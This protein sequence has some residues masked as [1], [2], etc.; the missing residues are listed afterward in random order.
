MSKPSI[1]VTAYRCVRRPSGAI[2]FCVLGILSSIVYPTD[3]NSYPLA[4]PGT[5]QPPA[6]ELTEDYLRFIPTIL[7]IA[8]PIVLGDKIG[9]VQLLYVGVANTAATQGAKF[10][11]NKV[12]VD[13]VRIGQRPRGRSSGY[14][15]PSGHAS[16]A[17]C[18]VF[19][20]CRRYGWRFGLPLSALLLLTMTT[21]VML[22]AHT[23]SAV[24]AGALIGFATTA[25]FTS[26]RADSGADQ[27][28][29]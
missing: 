15:M 28:P 24:I 1:F 16:M 18:A 29:E 22:N 12:T 10:L 21:R 3:L 11:F 14:N 4:A 23:I 5:P 6:V 2:A 13:H 20:L 9:L 26:P 19:F 17:A 25:W 7:Q 27:R 8:V